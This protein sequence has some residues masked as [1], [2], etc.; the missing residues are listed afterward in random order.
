MK[1]TII[2]IICVLTIASASK[3]WEVPEII[4]VLYPVLPDTEAFG[5][6]FICVGDQNGDGCDEL[7][8]THENRSWY[9]GDRHYANQVKIYYG[10]EEVD[11]EPGF[12]FSID[13]DDDSTG[14]GRH[15]NYIG[16]LTPEIKNCIALCSYIYHDD[17]DGYE[18]IVKIKIYNGGEDLDN[19]PEFTITTERENAIY[20]GQQNYQSRPVDLNGDG[21]HDLIAG[22][23]F[24][25]GSKLLAFWGGEEFDTIPDWEVYS[26]GNRGGRPDI[27]PGFDV[28]GDGYDDVLFKTRE[29]DNDWW[30]SIYLGGSPMDTTPVVR[31]MQ[32]HF[33]HAMMT[34][35]FSMLQDVNDD[36]YDDWVIH[37][38]RINSRIDGYY[39]FFG[40][41]EPDMEPDIVLE[42]NHLNYSYEGA[43]SGGDFNGDGKG[44]IVTTA[45]YGFLHDGEIH[46]HFGGE[47]LCTEP[48]II[49]NC[50]SAYGEEYEN[51]GFRVGAVG[52]Y[53]GDGADD[54]ATRFYERHRLVVFAGNRD[55]C[56]VD[57]EKKI[58]GVYE[59]YLDVSPNPFNSS[60]KIVYELSRK[61]HASITVF[62]VRGRKQTQ[63]VNGIIDKG[64]HLLSWSNQTAGIYFIV[65][66]TD[67]IQKVKKIVCLP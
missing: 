47:T 39:L 67:N 33:E 44:D 62:D 63:L 15:I 61:S 22:Q 2:S 40:S 37:F 14:I 56:S 45:W 50:A 25:D 55:W 12:V 10:G 23:R 30:Y 18:D 60:V 34:Y 27:S 31:F 41:E 58:P 48:D 8:L 17:H 13:E 11:N 6:D 9:G 21:Y 28:N 49:V 42:G 53:N 51:L 36:G 35:G 5:S 46:I 64:C 24:G 3:A 4:G 29:D 20:L 66:K 7:M 54:F 32:D 52:D 26:S 57:D 1:T 43:V 16:N 59:L 19:E 38:N 65:L